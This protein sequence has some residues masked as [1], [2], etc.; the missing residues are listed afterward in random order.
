MIQIN[1][2]INNY[3]D[4]KIIDFKDLPRCE[5]NKI[6]NNSI[7]HKIIDFKGL[8]QYES[9]KILN[10]PIE[11]KIIDLKD[12]SQY[13]LLSFDNLKYFLYKKFSNRINTFQKKCKFNTNYI[14]R[15]FK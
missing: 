6:T 11:H 14:K 15:S 13:E 10:N 4:H 3:I 12:L 8:S 2:I 5:S 7:E 1:K 9:N